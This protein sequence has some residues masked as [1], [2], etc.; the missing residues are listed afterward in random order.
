ML[1]RYSE[2][3]I[4]TIPELRQTVQSLDIDEGIRIQGSLTRFKNGGYIFLT[5]S[6]SKYCVNFCDKVLDK[7]SEQYIPGDRDEWH[8]YSGSDDVLKLIRNSAERP[9]NA[10]SY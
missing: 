1:K 2:S 7:K 10:W 3:R 6:K 4:R 5:K 8:Y 9:L